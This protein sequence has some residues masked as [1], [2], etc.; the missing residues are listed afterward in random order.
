MKP[1]RSDLKVIEVELNG[2]SINLLRPVHPKD[3]AAVLYDSS[4]LAV[5]LTYLRDNGFEKREPN[6]KRGAGIH[7]RKVRGIDKGFVVM[8]QEE[9]KKTYKHV[10]TLDAAMQVAASG[11]FDDEFGED[12]EGK[13]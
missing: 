1:Q 9:G 12:H 3:T 2:A 6:M 11:F 8:K 4:T 10:E 5:V 7:K 13:V